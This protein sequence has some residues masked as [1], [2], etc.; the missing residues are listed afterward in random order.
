MQRVLQHFYYHPYKFP[1]GSISEASFEKK[2]KRKCLNVEE[3]Y[4]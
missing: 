2:K 1:F 4:L 3:T